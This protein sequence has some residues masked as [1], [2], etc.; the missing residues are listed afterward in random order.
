MDNIIDGQATKQVEFL[1]SDNG[2]VEI[3]Q[4]FAR[5]VELGSRETLKVPIKVSSMKV[6]KYSI[7][8]HCLSNPNNT[9]DM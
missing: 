2:I 5:V 6:G 3:D 4:K 9:Y 8:V 7:I 1:S